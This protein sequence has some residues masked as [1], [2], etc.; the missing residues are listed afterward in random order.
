MKPVATP[1][2]PPSAP[3]ILAADQQT[4]VQ[5]NAQAGITSDD[6]R[7]AGM[8][9]HAAAIEARARRLYAAAAVQLAS[10]EQSLAAIEPPKRKSAAAA[11]AAPF[12]AQ[13][14]ALQS[15]MS[16]AGSVSAAAESSFNLIAE[17]RRAGF[18]A[19]LLTRSDSPL[20]PGFWT[21]LSGAAGDDSTRLLG[22]AQDAVTMPFQAPEPRGLLG[23]GAAL[24]L[25][26]VLLLPARRWLEKLGRRK[27]GE[28]VHPG[29]ARTGAALWIVAVDTGAPTLALLALHIGAEWGG[30]LSTEADKL[31][32]AVVGA[33]AWAAGIVSL[34]RVLATEKDPSQRL[35]PLPDDVARRM[36]L[37]LQIVALVTAA[38]SLLTRLNYVAGASVAATIATNCA[39]S[40]AYAAVA[41]LILISFGRGRRARETDQPADATPAPAWTLISV[42][43]ASA[44]A[45]TL[46]AVLAGYTTLAALTSGQIFWLAIIAAATF[47]AIRFV[48]DLM[49]AVFSQGGIASRG[50]FTLFSLRRSTIG[51]A[52]VLISAAL[53]LVILIAALS[54]ALTPF[55][56]GG[57]QLISHLQDLASPI[58]FGS[59]TISPAAIAA[60]IATFIL[61]MA[62]AR[63]V[64][65]WIVR[66]YLP[67]TDWDSGVRNSVTTG[68][69]YVGVILA[70]LCALAA[71]GLGFQQIAL[72]ASA[73]SVGIG[74]GL[75]QVVQ[76]FVSG[77]I[78][79]VERPVKVGDWVSIDGAEGDIRRIRVR[80]TEIETADH[81]MVIVPNSDLITK[82]VQNKTLGN[83]RILVQLPLAIVDAGQ[84]RKARELILDIAKCK[85]GIV[86]SPA[87]Q[88]LV[89]SLGAAGAV[90]LSCN[91]YAD[92]PRQTVRLRS[93]CY[94][95]IMEA[96]Q[97]HKIAF[98]GW[99]APA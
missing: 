20:S 32:G 26:A 63:A 93:D 80:A 84:V 35:L 33:T 12:L 53:Q 71:T 39:L 3:Q 78:L 47:L 14:S 58:E 10:V 74:F 60:G 68:V 49:S 38:G 22:L 66:R 87:P 67:V 25:A 98:S 2:P 31:A 99:S 83:S 37:P 69:G 91:F 9:A 30:L 50:L 24:A 54:L 4:L 46:A 27:S 19:R 95:Q 88:V 11:K 59:A 89:Q 16:Q 17:R 15:Q 76:N 7:L 13:R 85:S 28:S 82:A 43:L 75:Q 62:G 44:I 86:E 61:G 51:Q 72:I 41:G 79:L 48:D 94:F 56:N 70:M 45:V 64:Q 52:G 65:R 73:L 96:L 36:R 97:R 81:S 90:N 6:G 8:G 23:L 42:V 77:V 18:S 92:D 57:D 55:G 40:L 34:G 1:A 5:L 29:F 21:S